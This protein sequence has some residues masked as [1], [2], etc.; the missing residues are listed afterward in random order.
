NKAHGGQSKYLIESRE[1]LGIFE[2]FVDYYRGRYPAASRYD[3]KECIKTPSSH[4]TSYRIVLN[5]LGD[6]IAAGLLYSEHTKEK[7][8]IE[9]PQEEDWD[10]LGVSYSDVLENPS[11]PFFLGSEDIR[12]NVN[13]GGTVIPLMGG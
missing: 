2:G 10:T 1:Q 13:Q 12:S 7:R 5:P 4:Y 3:V 9:I 6:P 11:S 8:V